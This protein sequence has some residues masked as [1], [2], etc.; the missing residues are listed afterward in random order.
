MRA[1]KSIWNNLSPDI[2]QNC[3]VHTNVLPSRATIQNQMDIFNLVNLDIG[4]IQSH[5]SQL[6]GSVRGCNLEDL[7]NSAAKDLRLSN[8]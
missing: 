8:K 1:F 3:C 7:P 5:A 6:I 2:I 4:A